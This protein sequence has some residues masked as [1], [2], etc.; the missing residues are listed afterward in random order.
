MSRSL[1]D[2]VTKPC[3]RYRIL[4]PRTVYTYGSNDRIVDHYKTEET[5]KL[6]SKQFSSLAQ[7]QLQRSSTFLILVVLSIK[8][9]GFF[10]NY[11]A[12]TN[13]FCKTKVLLQGTV[14]KVS[15]P[16][17]NKLTSNSNIIHFQL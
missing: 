8:L 4:K 17:N 14:Q 5:H 1:I 6:A 12:N 2:F 3:V 11:L 10:I 7:V 13:N 15:Y 9:T 16:L